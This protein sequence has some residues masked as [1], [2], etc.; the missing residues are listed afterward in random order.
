MVTSF[1]LICWISVEKAWHKLNLLGH[2]L[3]ETMIFHQTFTD[4]FFQAEQNKKIL[5]VS[6]SFPVTIETNAVWEVICI[7]FY[8]ILSGSVDT[9][10]W[11][12]L[13]TLLKNY[14]LKK[15]THSFL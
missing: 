2:V 11:F 9:L 15:Y 3:N 14:F 4:L 10:I 1:F 13:S 8:S 12:I 7:I 5:S 6:E